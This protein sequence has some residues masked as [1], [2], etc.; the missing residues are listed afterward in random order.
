[1]SFF[2]CVKQAARD[3][4]YFLSI[5]IMCLVFYNFLLVFLHH[6]HIGEV[7]RLTIQNKQKSVNRKKNE[8]VLTSKMNPTKNRFLLTI[9]VRFFM[10]IEN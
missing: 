3:Y 5:Q 4:I 2:E 8:N 1:M 10:M 6:Q 9:T 7:V